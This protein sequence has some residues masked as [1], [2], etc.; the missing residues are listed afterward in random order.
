[1]ARWPAAHGP[2][3]WPKQ[4]LFSK[5]SWP[6]VSRKQLFLLIVPWP[7]PHG[8]NGEVPEMSR[9]PAYI[10][11]ATIAPLIIVLPVP[12]ALPRQVGILLF[13]YCLASASCPSARPI[14]HLIC[15]V[16]LLSRFLVAHPFIR[17]QLHGAHSLAPCVHS[18]C[19]GTF[20]TL[21]T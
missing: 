9:T 1:M 17:V 2:F 6:I 7:D 16:F 11:P 3:P 19:F 18:F 4:T 14:L 20:A 13:V 21:A 8:P 15:L 5:Q 10:Y 12:T